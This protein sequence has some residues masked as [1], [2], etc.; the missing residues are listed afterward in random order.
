M[1]AEITHSKEINVFFMKTLLF[2]SAFIFIRKTFHV[3]A[4][5]GFYSGAKATRRLRVSVKRRQVNW[6]T[7]AIPS[8]SHL[9]Y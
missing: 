8:A 3:K 2:E 5:K 1:L 9:I 7:S 6:S 4:H